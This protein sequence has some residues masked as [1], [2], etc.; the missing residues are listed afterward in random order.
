M[1]Q[2]F[3]Q[4][5]S[6]LSIFPVAALTAINY[7]KIHLRALRI[8]A[9]FVFL[10]ALGEI[11]YLFTHH[12]FKLNNA[13]PVGIFSTI[14]LALLILY[15]TQKST[16]GD[17]LKWVYWPI[18]VLLCIG[19]IYLLLRHPGIYPAK[20]KAAQ[21]LFIVLLAGVGFVKWLNIPDD[22]LYNLC[23]MLALF[24][25]HASSIATF[26]YS[27]VM[28]LHW[29]NIFGMFHD[30]FNLAANG[31]IMFAFINYLYPDGKRVQY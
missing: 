15:F 30:I 2:V 5:I 28:P 29:A 11:L 8:L 25:Y 22:K 18:Y 31:L 17:K 16:G 1:A 24:L 21:S 14:E 4:Y 13:L 26:Y 20:A 10:T 6:F 7:N 3:I 9:M 19:M 27:D 23:I 12:V